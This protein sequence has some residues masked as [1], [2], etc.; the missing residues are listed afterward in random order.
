MRWYIFRYLNMKKKSY[1]TEECRLSVMFTSFIGELKGVTVTN[2][3][4]I[5]RTIGANLF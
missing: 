3:H 2:G 1:V 5:I 4:N